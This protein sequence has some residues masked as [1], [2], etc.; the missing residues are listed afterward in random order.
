M[1]REDG[2]TPARRRRLRA[3]VAALER[4]LQRRPGGTAAAVRPMPVTLFVWNAFSM[5]GTVRTVLRQ[6]GALAAHG[7]EVT[8]VS[9]LRH[10]SQDAPAFPFPLGV[11]VEVLVDRRQ[12]AR[13]GPG[14]AVAR[15]LDGRPRVFG[16]FSIGRE[17]QASLL[18]DLRLVWRVLAARGM[19]VGT[20]IGLN[21]AIARFGHPAA[22]TIAQEHLQLRRYSPATRRAIARHFPRLDAIACLTEGEADDYRRKFAE[23]PRVVV[24]P[25]AIPD[26]LPPRADAAARRIVTVGRLA[27]SKRFHALVD[28]FAAVAD[29]HPDWTLRIVGAGTERSRI[30]AAVER[31]G[32]AQRVELVGETPDVDAE[33]AAASVFAL[34]SRFESFGIVLLEAMAAGLAVVSIDCPRGPRELLTDG[35]NA[36]KVADLGGLADGLDRLMRDESLRRRLGAAARRD[37]AAYGVDAVTRRWLELLGEL[38]A[39]RPARVRL[40]L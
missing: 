3:P 12:L 1:E 25:N 9:V 37:V 23:G 35:R 24:V 30:A 10:R 18:T 16:A 8:I 34:S 5:G 15:W 17:W 38:E 26:R 40:A 11:R 19:V 4:L 29:A 6:A 7:R 36:L 31:H 14:G 39:P 2:T 27:P 33:L 32:L 28:A 13:P 20:R 21:L 22:R